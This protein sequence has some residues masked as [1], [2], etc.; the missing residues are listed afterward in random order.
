MLQKSFVAIK[1]TAV[2]RGLIGRILQRFE[3]KQYKVV[4][5]KMLIPTKE[6]GEQH[7]EE[8][9]DKPFFEELVAYITSGPI[10]AM[11]I[12]G[13]EAIL[14]IRK[15]IGATDPLQADAGTV[16]ADF[17]QY[18]RY[19]MIH[20]ADCVDSAEREIA[21]YFDKEDFCNYEL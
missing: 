19:N 5:M 21:I 9:K 7:Y 3:D 4:A 17:A 6:Q 2:K 13:E 12:E 20:A 14:G 1:P 10:V 8:H 18:K 15:L 11:V 16:R